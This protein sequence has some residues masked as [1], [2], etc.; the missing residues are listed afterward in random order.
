MHTLVAFAISLA[1]ISILGIRYRIMPFISLIGASILYGLLAGM[2]PEAVVGAISRGLGGVFSLLGI[3][4]FSGAVI[5]QVLKQGSHLDRIVSDI[6]GIIRQPLYASGSAGYLLSIPLMCSITSFI[7]LAPIVSCFRGEGSSQKY[8]LYAAAIG[9]LISFAL[10]Y[11]S[12][13]VYAITSTLGIFTAFPWQIDFLTIPLSLALLVILLVAWRSKYQ[14]AV[15]APAA[16]DTGNLTPRWKAWAP[17]G[18]PVLMFLLGI[19]VPPLHILS[20]INVAL[21]AGLMVALFSSTQ[22]L[23]LDAVSRGTK[24]AGIIIFD[25]SGAGAL[26]AVIAASNFPI[27]AY[28]ALSGIFPLIILPFLLASLIQ[29]AQGS[30]VTTAVVTS[31][32]LSSSPFGTALHPLAL[33]LMICAGSCVISYVSDPFFW[34][35]KRIT[36]DDFSTVARMYTI[37]LA[38]VGVAIFIV[39]VLVQITLH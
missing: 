24:N 33:L 4:I 5:A 35:L 39:A 22:E 31:G 12:P 7:I 14:E 25:L 27:Q 17:L 11:P 38:M 13:A 15:D 16:C 20:N 36:G 29:T 3:V 28:E 8:A 34:L 26:G 37:P 10:I 1:L 32:I 19:A 23:R 30:R 9:G 21:L 18:V 6:R 2:A